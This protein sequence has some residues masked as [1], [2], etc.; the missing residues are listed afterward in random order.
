VVGELRAS[1]TRELGY[2]CS[3]GIAINKL[4]SK[5]ACGL[6]KPNQQTL[7]L[8][9]P[10][11]SAL[12][13]GL[14]IDRLQ[15]LGGDLGEKVKLALAAQLKLENE[16]TSS[17]GT[18]T[19]PTVTCGMVAAMSRARLCQLFGEEKATYLYSMSRGQ[20]EERVQDRSEVKS[21]GASK[22]FFG[23]AALGTVSDADQ[24]L[25]NFSSEL[26]E[27]LTYHRDEYNYVPTL[28]TVSIGTKPAKGGE[29]NAPNVS[30]SAKLDVGKGGA[31]IKVSTA[32]RSAFRKW[33][34][35][36]LSDASALPQP[37]TTLGVSL[38][39]MVALDVNTPGLANW[40]TSASSSA[41]RTP[42]SATQT[43]VFS[44]ISNNNTSQRPS[45]AMS[46]SNS[47]LFTAPK[48]SEGSY[49]SPQKRPRTK[50]GLFSA[51]LNGT[52]QIE[53]SAADG[54]PLRTDSQPPQIES[55]SWASAL[56]QMREVGI[57]D[58]WSIIALERCSGDLNAAMNYVFT[59]DMEALITK[60]NVASKG[61]N[62][63]IHN[64]SRTHTESTDNLSSP[65]STS[66]ANS[67]NGVAA[68]EI[69]SDVLAALP[70]EIAEEV[71]QQMALEER[72]RKK[73]TM[74]TS[75]SSPSSSSSSS[76]SN[77]KG[78]KSKERAPLG[79][80]ELKN[81]FQAKPTAK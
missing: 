49:E 69:D 17:D 70:P 44:S 5:L 33:C 10:A 19:P 73:T 76:P 30:R 3:G 15:G 12:L 66:R 32:A 6:H 68:N 31:A 78:K 20:Q 65:S 18:P 75:S 7:V 16:G 25:G 11:T 50:V 56:K 41:S 77:A 54:A 1:V 35:T 80:Q 36:T 58:D 40:M 26:W 24:W 43:P 57:R 22:N 37:I 62:E 59:N 45:E 55:P 38:G 71:R 2:T 27:R 72:A 14:P 34:G 4:L 23:G 74:G 13:E 9:G 61:I 60:D 46:S 28:V 53:E 81:F 8:P 39:C 79:T 51:P 29:Y 47:L 52:V 48:R 21:L 63:V 42:P 67:F 64:A